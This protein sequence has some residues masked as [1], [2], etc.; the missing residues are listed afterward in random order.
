MAVCAAQGITVGKTPTTFDPWASITRQQLITMVVRAAALPAPP[1]GYT[2]PFTSGQFYPE[3]HFQNARKAH[4]AGLLEGLQGLGAGAAATGYNFTA[5]ASRGECAQ[6]LYNL[7]ARGAGATWTQVTASASSSLS[8]RSDGS[9]W[10]WGRNHHGQL[11]DGTDIDR[12]VPTRIGTASDWQ[13]V[14]AVIHHSL[15]LKTDGSLWAWGDNEYGQLGDGTDIDRRVPTR[16]GTASDWQVVAAGHHHSLALKTDGS[17]W[18]WGRNQYGQLGDGTHT[19]RWIPA[20]IG[21]DSDWQAV[22]SGCDHCLALKTDGSLWAW[23][24]NMSGKLGDGTAGTNNNRS[25]PT[26]IGTAFDWQVVAAGYHHSLALK[27]DGS[28]W[29]WGSS[30]FGKLG[31][32][33]GVEHHQPTRVAGD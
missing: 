16:I 22:A 33:T 25:A 3:E 8:V 32:G 24:Y 14:A 1:T 15:A 31:D 20:R 19:D 2:P 4:H 9:L 11:G 12:R 23:G 17:L 6:L 30:S 29:A 5:P 7:L 28:L 26:R 27:T 21:T 10:G 18:T 13:A